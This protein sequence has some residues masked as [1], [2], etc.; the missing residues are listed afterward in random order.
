MPPKSWAWDHFYTDGQKYK[1]NKYDSTAWCLA[2][3]Q[4]RMTEL[5]ESD[6][7]AVANGLLINGRNEE[8]LK[9]EGKQI[10]T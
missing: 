2:C 1:T 9:A 8:E 10:L 4:S 3:L 5:R 6:S 7:A